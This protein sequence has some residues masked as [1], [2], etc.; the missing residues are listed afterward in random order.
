VAPGLVFG[1]SFETPDLPQE[2]VSLATYFGITEVEDKNS[3]NSV[4][5]NFLT[6]FFKR[7][8]T[9]KPLALLVHSCIV[10]EVSERRRP[11][12]AVRMVSGGGFLG[13]SY[14]CGEEHLNYSSH[15]RKDEGTVEINKMR[16][17]KVPLKLIPSCF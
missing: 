2:P 9:L 12:P 14:G 16:K 1:P 13:V 15:R 11:S 3:F 8:H 7:K 10:D 6:P 5:E 4:V 17:I